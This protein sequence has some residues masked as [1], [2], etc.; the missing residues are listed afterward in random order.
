MGQVFT[1]RDFV[2]QADLA[3]AGEGVCPLFD[4][5]D[6]CL[7]DLKDLVRVNCLLDGDWPESFVDQGNGSYFRVSNDGVGYGT[8]VVGCAGFRTVAATHSIPSPERVT[9]SGD[10]D[11]FTIAAE[12][13]FHERDMRVAT[14]RSSRIWHRPSEGRGPVQVDLSTTLDILE[15]LPLSTARELVGKDLF[16]WYMLSSMYVN[17]ITYDSNLLRFEGADGNV[18]EISVSE[19]YNVNNGKRRDGHLFETPVPLGSWIELDKTVGSTWL[20]RS[21]SI[22]YDIGDTHGMTLGVQGWWSGSDNPDDDN[23][24][25]WLEWIDVPRFLEPGTSQQLDVR[26]TSMPCMD[27]DVPRSRPPWP[28]RLW[29]K[30]QDYAHRMTYDYAESG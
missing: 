26:V 10:P 25:I 16:R 14:V 11:H 9:V 12:G 30:P 3:A 18:Q 7:G 1:G 27:R 5:A 23:L 24:N 20:P 21:P 28:K 19:A 4:G 29:W 22:R 13:A 8:S 17:D 2:V 6:V 15:K